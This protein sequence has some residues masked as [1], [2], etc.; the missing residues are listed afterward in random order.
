MASSNDQNKTRLFRKPDMWPARYS[1]SY[2]HF[3]ALIWQIPAWS[4]AVFAGLLTALD[5]LSA[6]P[7][8]EGKDICGL[9]VA[10]VKD[11]LLLGGL[12][13]LLASGYT[14]LRFR[15]HQAYTRHEHAPSLGWF[16][17]AQV[18]LQCV[19]WMQCAAVLAMLVPM[20]LMAVGVDILVLL[21]GVSGFCC[22]QLH[23]RWF[24]SLSQLSCWFFS[25]A[26][27]RRTCFSEGRTPTTSGLAASNTSPA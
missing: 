15:V 7:V 19:V 8:C 26:H 14:L 10:L 17:G 22:P 25:S 12:A 13:F 21:I 2:R 11:L 6:K 16:P 23:Y 24:A 5:V 20:A 3:D 9:E 1:S 27:R 4:T 18:F